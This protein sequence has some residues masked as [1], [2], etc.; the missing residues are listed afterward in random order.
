MITIASSDKTI[1]LISNYKL[2]EPQAGFI[3]VDISSSKELSDFYNLLIKSNEIREIRFHNHSENHLLGWFKEMFSVV[4]AAGGVVRN[5]KG[6]YLFIFRN[7]KWDLP[8]GKIEKGES[9]RAAA[10]REVE[11]E[12]G[13][14]GLSIVKELKTSYHTYLVGNK[15]ILKPTYWFEMMCSDSSCLK[16]QT[17]EGI[18]EVKWFRP[19]DFDSIKKNTFPSII[20][21]ISAL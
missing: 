14:S 4:E 5:D 2:F 21:L 3:S 17:E 16:P 8:K 7:G 20:D 1:R 18:T 19:A 11:E 13:I 15:S 10:I 12:C 6:E 9:V